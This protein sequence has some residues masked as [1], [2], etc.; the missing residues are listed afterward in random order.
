MEVLAFSEHRGCFPCHSPSLREESTAP[1]CLFF[2]RVQNVRERAVYVEVLE[3]PVCL[4]GISVRCLGLAS[5]A[6]RIDH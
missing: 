5:Q 4:L 3:S 1:H 2:T 6:S